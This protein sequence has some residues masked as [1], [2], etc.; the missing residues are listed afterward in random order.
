MKDIIVLGA[1]MVG[2]A[3][4]LALQKRGADVTLIDRG[5][6]GRETSYG[7]AGIIQTE[8]AEPYAMPRKASEL[9]RIALKQ[10]N[11]V[12]WHLD[13]LPGHARALWQYFRYSSRVQHHQISRTYVQLTSRADSD[14]APLI[15]AA[16]AEALIRRDGFRQAYRDTRTLDEAAADADRLKQEYGV[17]S[18][19]LDSSALARAEPNMLRSLAGAL[20]WTGS[21]TC[22]DP[23][24]LVAA[25]ADL[26]TARG[27]RFIKGDA[28]SLAARD[29]GGWSVTPVAG[30]ERIEAA[31]A[32]IALG[33]WSASLCKRFGLVVPLL[34]KRGYHRHFHTEAGPNMTL[35]DVASSAVMAPMQVGLR[36]TTGAEIARHEAAPDPAQIT[37]AE[38]AVRELFALGEPVE[39]APWLGT[40]PCMPDMLPVVGAVPQQPGLWAHFGHGHQGFTLGP[41]TADLL[42]NEIAGEIPV[43]AAL[44]PANR[45]RAA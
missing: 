14:H 11:E 33:P 3:T 16:G 41:T 45:F 36:I 29:G 5:A 18:A 25:Y 42:A 26:F 1:G 6:P 8:A 34:G 21:W 35:V 23:G 31:E 19:I 40:R 38:Q 17:P 32:V 10:G 30:G 37:R 44:A 7:N 2:V 39:P 12:R 24:G 43:P 28:M 9:V 4:A 27:G 13:A 22:T 15:A 20:H